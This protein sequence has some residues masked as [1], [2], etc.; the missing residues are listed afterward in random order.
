MSSLTVDA[1]LSSWLNPVIN[2][3]PSHFYPIAHIVLN[4]YGGNP[5]P[6][7][8]AARLKETSTGEFVPLYVETIAGT[9]EGPSGGRARR[10]ILD[11]NLE[12]ND[13]NGHYELEVT[14]H[15]APDAQ[16]FTLQGFSSNVN[17][18]ISI[19]TDLTVSAKRANTSTWTQSTTDADVIADAVP[20]TIEGS[21]VYTY[22]ASA[23][24]SYTPWHEGTAEDGYFIGELEISGGHA[25]Y[26]V[27][28][29]EDD[30]VEAIRVSADIDDVSTDG[31]GKVRLYVVGSSTSTATHPVDLAVYDGEGR[32]KT[33]SF[34]WGYIATPTASMATADG[35][36]PSMSEAKEGFLY[37]D[38]DVYPKVLTLNRTSD[39][40]FSYSGTSTPAVLASA[41]AGVAG[42]S[43]PSI[44]FGGAAA[45]DTPYIIEKEG[46][47][48]V[49]NGYTFSLQDGDTVFYLYQAMTIAAGFPKLVVPNGSAAV[50]SYTDTDGTTEVLATT[51][52]H[53]GEL[54]LRLQW[55]GGFGSYTFSGNVFN[56]DAA[57]DNAATSPLEFGADQ[58]VGPYVDTTASRTAVLQIGNSS[59]AWPFETP[60]AT[61]GVHDTD[62]VR[63][64]LAGILTAAS[65]AA[66]VATGTD[67]LSTN[68]AEVYPDFV[69]R[70]PASVVP[71][72]PLFL[73]LGSD[74]LDFSASDVN[75]YDLGYIADN[76]AFGF[77]STTLTY[78]VSGGAFN[79]DGDNL[80]TTAP[81]TTI[82]YHTPTLQ[83][84]DAVGTSTGD[85]P[86]HVSF[87]KT[88]TITTTASEYTLESDDGVETT[89]PDYITWTLDA[90]VTY[91]E[92]YKPASGSDVTR[93]AMTLEIV[94]KPNI[95]CTFVANAGE[96]ETSGASCQ[97][98]VTIK[99]PT[100]EVSFGDPNTLR[101]GFPA[102]T[103]S[104]TDQVDQPLWAEGFTD[105]V[106]TFVS[107]TWT[108]TTI[109]TTT[110]ATDPPV[111]SEIVSSKF[112]TNHAIDTMVD[113]ADYQALFPYGDDDT[114]FDQIAQFHID[115][116]SLQTTSVR[117]RLAII[118]LTSTGSVAETVDGPEVALDAINYANI[119]DYN[120]EDFT[121]YQRAV[122]S[123]LDRETTADDLSEAEVPLGSLIDSTKPDP[124]NAGAFLENHNIDNSYIRIAITADNLP[125]SGTSYKLILVSDGANITGASTAFQR[126]I[127]INRFDDVAAGATLSLI[128]TDS[129]YLDRIGLKLGN[130]F[131]VVDQ[132]ID[133]LELDYQL[134]ASTDVHAVEEISV[135]EDVATITVT[136]HGLSTG[137]V[138][139][140]NGADDEAFNVQ[141][142]AISGVTA[143]T[144]NIAV[145]SGTTAPT[146]LGK[147]IKSWGTI[148]SGTGSLANI[149][150]HVLAKLPER[151]INASSDDGSHLNSNLHDSADMKYIHYRFQ[152]RNAI[153][154]ADYVNSAIYAGNREEGFNASASVYNWHQAIGD[155]T[156]ESL[157]DDGAVRVRVTRQ[158]FNWTSVSQGVVYGFT[159]DLV[160]IIDSFPI[161]DGDGSI[162]TIPPV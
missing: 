77:N 64:R 13:I 158:A 44:T 126:T 129:R 55:S 48:F 160:T 32:I 43:A 139:D 127:K 128:D 4:A 118:K 120:D 94:G 23:T 56:V 105:V 159:S 140:L 39:G 51:E 63:V 123:G 134:Q 10:I 46:I 152:L 125:A 53:T 86:I 138:V 34:T 81:F 59:I 145:A 35:L 3:N 60:D 79:V 162:G 88:P 151:Y 11:K 47:T 57:V 18:S 58:T 6:I 112:L 90:A 150:T 131:P 29:K 142:V 147:L 148:A 99:V 31:I 117:Y 122:P 144:F 45:S 40:V 78:T 41:I 74:S 141:G 97:G 22:A 49:E 25:P 108:L 70:V 61:D 121:F 72:F 100:S 156:R 124:D 8:H 135:A 84:S 37:T 136:G 95:I 12:A 28:V 103:I 146:T 21:T 110:A 91:A 20:W 85:I 15:N 132:G 107:A 71:Y 104:R 14:I 82:S 62:S 111:R 89:N 16:Y 98:S 33:F 27:H 68:I 5:T 93:D 17:V 9:D 36:T 106:L 115:L 75:M 137:A 130:S 161:V 7:V 69:T 96:N 50:R 133:V 24:S 30:G 26:H 113:Y 109:D 67:A 114:V 116:E 154:Q 42:T 92:G 52:S 157:R 65:G 80:Q 119:D 143:D 1:T 153:G 155:F 2:Y 38:T 66:A 76:G 101:L 54:E 149:N 83:I 19:S 102:K 73:D 87:F